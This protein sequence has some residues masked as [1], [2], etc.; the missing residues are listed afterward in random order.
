MSMIG[1]DEWDT[2]AA[3][4][5]I[6]GIPEDDR[7]DMPW[8]RNRIECLIARIRNSHSS[9]V[10]IYTKGSCWDFYLILNEVYPEAIA[11]YNVTEGHIYTKVDKRYFDIRGDVTN[12]VRNLNKQG[13]SFVRLPHP[14]YRPWEWK[15]HSV[16]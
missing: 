11:Y 5:E 8:G 15:Q 6:E 9:M 16:A 7:L 12:K 14:D 10:E 13:D 4:Q 2:N 3:I 1:R